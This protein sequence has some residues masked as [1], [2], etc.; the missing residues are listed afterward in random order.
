ML[1]LAAWYGDGAR[2]GRRVGR[3]KT[4]RQRWKEK[5]VKQP[6]APLDRV[7]NTRDL[8]PKGLIRGPVRTPGR[9]ALNGGERTS[10]ESGA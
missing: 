1:A 6:L 8:P 2:G 3:S 10:V 7:R 4:A 9:G 5:P